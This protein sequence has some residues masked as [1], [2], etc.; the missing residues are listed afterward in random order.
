MDRT[1]PLQR[2][3]VPDVVSGVVVFLVALPLCLGIAQA[4]NAP[5]FSGIL[6]G[7]VGGIVVALISGS[8]TSVTG[9]AAGLTA[10]VAAQIEQLGSFESFLLAVVV[11]GVLQCIFA[12]VK[13]GG[14]AAFVPTSVIKGLLAAIGVIL[15]LSNFLTCWARTGIRKV[16][17]LSRSRS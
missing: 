14:L 3:W 10:V 12:L 17:C 1:I 2:R 9:P 4:S 15:I 7:I 16:R 11:G 8:H 6:A 13:A 5:V